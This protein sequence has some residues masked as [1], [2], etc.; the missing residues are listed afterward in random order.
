M[1][2]SPKI[3]A[4]I[5]P[6]IRAQFFKDH[7][8]YEVLRDETPIIKRAGNKN[9]IKNFSIPFT[10]FPYQLSSRDQSLISGIKRV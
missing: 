3:T 8:P 7:I 1:E 6:P 9:A 4:K 2:K 10:S 5:I